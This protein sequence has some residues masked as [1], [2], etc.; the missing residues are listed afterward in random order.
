MSMMKPR[1][2]I[3]IACWLPR[4]RYTSLVKMDGYASLKKRWVAIEN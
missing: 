1:T 2:G 4:P 3:I